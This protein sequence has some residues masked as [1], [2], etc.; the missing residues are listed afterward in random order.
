MG[1]NKRR[2]KAGLYL[3]GDL[4]LLKAEALR[5]NLLGPI[6]V[7]DQAWGSSS[8]VIKRSWVGAAFFTVSVV[9]P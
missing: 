8:I 3:C 4:Q 2:A 1:S 6:W 5:F 9:C 7:N